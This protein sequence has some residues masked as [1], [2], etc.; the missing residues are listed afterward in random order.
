VIARPPAGELARREGLTG[1]KSALAELI[2][3]MPGRMTPGVDK[4]PP[5]QEDTVA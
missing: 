2:S 3:R 4:A 1:I 5:V